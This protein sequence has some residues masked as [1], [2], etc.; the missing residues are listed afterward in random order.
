MEEVVQKVADQVQGIKL[1][2][3]KRKQQ[4]HKR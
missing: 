2:S 1:E 4:G 3:P